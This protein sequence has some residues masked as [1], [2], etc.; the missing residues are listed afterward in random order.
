MSFS[1]TYN[2]RRL[3]FSLT[4]VVL[5]SL[6]PSPAD[7]CSLVSSSSLGSQAW[8]QAPGTNINSIEAKTTE[9]IVEKTAGQQASKTQD[10]VNSSSQTNEK[11]MEKAT[12][13]NLKSKKKVKKGFWEKILPILLLLMVV[14]IILSRLPTPNFEVKISHG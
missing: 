8:A 1:M 12:K 10:E 11:K 6:S 7:F 9:I 2:L 13:A 3:L 5:T 14:A 4:L